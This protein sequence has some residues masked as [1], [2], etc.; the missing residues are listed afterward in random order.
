MP[1]YPH[2]S[3]PFVC[4]FVFTMSFSS[5]Y[6]E[7]N[8]IGLRPTLIQHNLI[9]NGLQLQ[10]PIS[11]EDSIHKYWGLGLQNV[12]LG[13]I[14]QPITVAYM[15]I[16]DVAPVQ[17][18]NLTLLIFFSPH[19]TLQLLLTAFIFLKAMCP[20]KSHTSSQIDSF[21][22][23]HFLFIRLPSLMSYQFSHILYISWTPHTRLGVSCLCSHR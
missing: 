14:F 21:F 7:T 10:D 22:L 5:S 15:V 1:L 8:H 18:S 4:L 12:F 3:L 13:D 9:L 19:S 23:E 20:L 17:F 6:K 11:K 16:D 2:S